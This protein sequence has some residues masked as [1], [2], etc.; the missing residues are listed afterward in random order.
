MEDWLSTVI[1][2]LAGGLLTAG[3]AW[4]NDTRLNERERER[5]REERR[6]RLASR[7]NE[8]QRETLLA[9]Q[10]ACQRLIRNA[11]ASLHH[12]IVA[13]RTTGKWQKG[14]LPNGLSDEQLDLNT[15]TMLLATRVRDEEIR[16]L[17]EELRIRLT[18]VFQ[19]SGE[20]EAEFILMSAGSIQAPLLER[21]GQLLR[22][23]DDDDK[24]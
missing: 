24:F 8:F 23:L 6:D 9:L 21:I 4:L 19:T 13:Y 15:Q 1:S 17:S 20:A 10:V 18:H 12:D 11:G 2:V 3:S 7:R 5:R 16:R 22:N 14:L